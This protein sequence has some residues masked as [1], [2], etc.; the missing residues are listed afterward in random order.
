MVVHVS[1]TRPRTTFNTEGGILKR[2]D[3]VGGSSLCRSG[4]GIDFH[5]ALG[6]ITIV[7]LIITVFST[8][9]TFTTA[10]QDLKFET[11]SDPVLVCTGAIVNIIGPLHAKHR[12]QLRLDEFDRVLHRGA[13]FFIQHDIDCFHIVLAELFDHGR[14]LGVDG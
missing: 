2:G 3:E 10:F 5:I 13:L 4:G 7:S 1:I 6:T 11:I 9:F 14:E 8:T 12:P